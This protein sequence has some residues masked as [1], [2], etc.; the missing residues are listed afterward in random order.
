M[1]LLYAFK[2]LLMKISFIVGL[3]L[4]AFSVFAQSYP[5]KATDIS[6]LLI[7]EKAPQV[8]LTH[9]NGKTDSLSAL[10]AKQETVIIFY[11]GGWCPFCNV[12]LAELQAIESDIIKL[13]YQI[14]AISPDSPESLK[15]SLD[16]HK[17]NYQLLSDAS[18]KAA[19][20]FGIAFNVPD[21]SKERLAKSSGGQNP[22]QL[23]V[24]SVFVMNK[25][26][27]IL[28]EYINPDYK[29]RLPANLLLTVLKELKPQP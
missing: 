8:V 28:F 18:M 22:G 7:G 25:Q 5:D 12:Q 3:T 13:G 26:G 16:K 19:Q 11:R 15:A 4:L 10:L 1:I 27:E 14:V 6:P 21:S 24:P 9:L 23:P 17:L 29:K 2:H 20:L